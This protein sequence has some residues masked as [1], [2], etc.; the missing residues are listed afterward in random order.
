MDMTNSSKDLVIALISSL[1]ALILAVT[2]DANERFIEWAEAYE[3]LEIDELPVAATAL[4]IGFAWFSWRR[5]QDLL[6]IELTLKQRVKE[7]ERLQIAEQEGKHEAIEKSHQLLLVGEMTE[8]LLI[9]DSEEEALR[10]FQSYAGKLIKPYSGAIIV[11]P[12]ESQAPLVHQWGSN[13]KN[14]HSLDFEAC[15]C[16]RSNRFYDTSMGFCTRSCNKSTSRQLCIP[17]SNMNNCHGVIAIELSDEHQDISASE[18]T[19]AVAPAASVLAITLSNLDLRNDLFHQSIKDPLTSLLNRRGWQERINTINNDPMPNSSFSVIT[20]DIDNFKQI[21][22]KLGH[23][24]GDQT[25]VILSTVINEA[26]RS[27]DLACR[28][29]G[30]EIVIL[31][32]DIVREQAIERAL[33]IATNFKEKSQRYFSGKEIELSVSSG[34][35]SYPVDGI[36]LDELIVKSDSY[37]YSAKK[38]GKNRV[39]ASLNAEEDRVV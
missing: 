12:N 17:V 3:H 39:A 13:E 8:S 24:A 27:T 5:W 18:I 21:N 1:L 4:A 7:I 38:H 11:K 23:E 19:E 35:A 31:L 32:S 37:L 16:Y 15:W 2:F 29:G 34:V 28:L 9:S 30:D 14:Y 25:L 33:L 6:K 22:D 20:L 36:H 10:I 26:T